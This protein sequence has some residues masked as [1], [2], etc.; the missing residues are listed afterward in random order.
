MPVIEADHLQS[1]QAVLSFRMGLGLSFEAQ[2]I[3]IWDDPTLSLADA[4]DFPP[5]KVSKGRTGRAAM[6]RVFDNN[7]DSRI[8]IVF[9][10]LQFTFAKIVLNPF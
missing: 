6:A 4:D 3:S 2:E 7:S 10:Q 1:P 8:V 5:E 9:L